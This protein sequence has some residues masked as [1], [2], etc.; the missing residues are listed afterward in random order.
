M[1][2]RQPVQK[3]PGDK[4]LTV[5]VIKFID[6]ADVWVINSG[7]SFAS[8]WKRRRA[9]G[10]LDTSSGRNLRATKQATEFD[11]LRLVDH[12]HPRAD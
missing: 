2:Q 12:T 4:R 7:R 10:S 3:F 5:L 1:F 8:R 11:I 6:G 9:Y